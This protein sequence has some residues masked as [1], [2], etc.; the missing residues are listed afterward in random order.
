MCAVGISLVDSFY[1][2][3]SLN[4]GLWENDLH[5]FYHFCHLPHAVESYNVSSCERG[6][7]DALKKERGSVSLSRHKYINTHYSP[8]K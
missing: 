7:F 3:N 1:E 5:S 4:V 2:K 6:P 8:Y